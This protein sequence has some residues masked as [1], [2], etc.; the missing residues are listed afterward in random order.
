MVNKQEAYDYIKANLK[1]SRFIH[2]LGVIS[3]AKKLAVKN[4]V[5]EEKA[6]IAALCHDI[7]KN[8]P[9]EEMEKVIIKNNIILSQDEKNT[10]ELWHSILAPI[11]AKE[12]LK[13]DDSEILSA[14]R[15]HTTGKEN[16]SKLDKII[17]IADMIE[18]SRNFDGLEE[19]RKET[20][21]NLDNGVLLGLTHS[22]SFLL[23]KGALVDVN[24]IKARNYLINNR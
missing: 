23:Q 6:E 20:I 22:I 21:N 3:V 19:I 7:A 15:W 12:K 24:S 11:Y 8:V 10:K 18:P 1:E 17:Y 9:K 4:G 16:M 14:I 13:I 5:D 2:T